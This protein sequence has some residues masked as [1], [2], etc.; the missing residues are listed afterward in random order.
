MENYEE[1]Y[2]SDSQW[3]LY[4]DEALSFALE[5]GFLIEDEIFCEVTDEMNLITHK[6]RH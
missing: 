5:L 4:S 1:F 3:V 2:L 6:N